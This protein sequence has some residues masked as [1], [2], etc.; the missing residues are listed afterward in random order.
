MR[1]VVFGAA[2]L[3]AASPVLSAKPCEELGAEISAKL[4]SKGVRGYSLKLV[5]AVEVKDQAVVGSCDNGAMKMVY[6]R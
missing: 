5:P 6:R 4:E 1:H 2:I 3:L